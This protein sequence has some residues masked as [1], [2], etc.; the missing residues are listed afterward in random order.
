MPRNYTITLTASD[1]AADPRRAQAASQSFVLTVSD[2]S[3]P[4]A[5]R[6]YIGDKVAVVGQPFQL[7]DHG[8]G[9]RP[10]TA[11]PSAPWV[12]PLAPR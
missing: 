6:A 11:R 7:H 2:P 10:A 4:P 9:R 1:P 12:C 5:P 3:L 8:Y